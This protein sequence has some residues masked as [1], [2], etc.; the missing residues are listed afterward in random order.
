MP[1]KIAVIVWYKIFP[2]HF[3]GQKVIATFMDA[4]AEQVKVECICSADNVLPSAVLYP[5]HTILPSTKWQIVNPFVWIRL[6]KWVKRE[7]VS[8]IIFEHPYHFMAA[9]C[10][11]LLGK[12][13]IIHHAH[14]I[15]FERFELRKKWFWPIVKWVERKMCKLAALNIYIT[16]EDKIKAKAYFGVDENKCF[17]LPYAVQKRN[18]LNKAA[19]KQKLLQ[20]FGWLENEHILIFN[21]TLDYQPNALAVEA[22]F[23]HLVP[24]LE[25]N[26]FPFRII[27]A[28]KLGKSKYQYL[29][30]FMNEKVVYVGNVSNI[31]EWMASADVFINTVTKGAGV[32]TKTLEAVASGLPVV[33]FGNMLNGIEAD[34]V[35]GRLMVAAP[36]NWQSF[37]EGIKAALQSDS[38]IPD[39]FWQH[40]NLDTYLPNL[41]ERI[42]NT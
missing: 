40:Y 14:N 28:G 9:W 13:S 12:A 10:C 38:S 37:F 25:Q 19:A 33:C 23:D 39:N 24:I 22:I 41:I 3:G 36:N 6:V 1:K 21:G 2:A 11:K 20:Q 35:K 42:H 15:E 27:I 5:V 29:E 32:Q 7:Q 8:H 26:N 17:V 4:L 34:A 30:K 16:A 18:Q 31:D